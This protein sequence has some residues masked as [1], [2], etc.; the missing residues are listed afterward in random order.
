MGEGS[1]RISRVLGWATLVFMV[2]GL[3]A[4]F[5]YAPREVTMGD[6]QRI[7]YF[8]L[9][10]AWLMMLAFGVVFAGSILYLVKKDRKWDIIA[11]ASAE[12]AVVFSF[13]V[14]TTG[15]IWAKSAWGAWWTWDPRLTSTL[16]LWIVF[17][18]YL[19]LRGSITDRSRR[20]S[21][22]SVYGIVGFVDVPIVF[23]SIRW[24]RTIHPQLFNG[25][26]MQMAPPMILTLMVCLVAFSLLYVFFL[27]Q[28]IRLET[29]RDEVELLKQDISY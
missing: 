25:L 23:M 10:A 6:V 3:Y 2:A 14:M 21:I 29:M 5:I 4:A 9:A 13:V 19:M 18:G 20:A 11:A 26:D 17:I 16:V 27:L 1:F 24:W 22:S 8:H 12:I 7:F 15:P 28:R